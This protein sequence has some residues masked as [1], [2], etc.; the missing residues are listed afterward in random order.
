VQ[1]YNESYGT[2]QTPAF[3]TGNANKLREVKEILS[4]GGHPIQIVSQEL[5]GASTTSI[6]LISRILMVCP[7]PELQGTT[8]EVAREK[9]RR[10]AAMVHLNTRRVPLGF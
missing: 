7:V 8:Q 2:Q 3:V 1:N 5:D 4:A 10:A 9:C 6:S